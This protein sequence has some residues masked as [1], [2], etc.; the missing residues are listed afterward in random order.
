MKTLNLILILICMAF[1]EESLAMK[2]KGGAVGGASG[3][4]ITGKTCP[5][6]FKPVNLKA[7]KTDCKGKS[8]ATDYGTEHGWKQGNN[9]GTGDLEMAHMIG[10]KKVTIGQFAVDFFINEYLKDGSNVK[11]YCL[12]YIPRIKGEGAVGAQ[13][14]PSPSVPILFKTKIKVLNGVNEETYFDKVISSKIMRPDWDSAKWGGHIRLEGD[15]MNFSLPTNVSISEINVE[16]L[17]LAKVEFVSR[18]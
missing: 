1:V 16:L 11:E 2:P 6:K 10:G 13:Y 17:P 18:P 7:I 9:C 3:L 4:Q 12:S 14:L 8:F 5:A 15:T